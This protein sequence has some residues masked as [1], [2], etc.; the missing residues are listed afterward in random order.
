MNGPVQII[1]VRGPVQASAVNGPLTARGL[2]ADAK[3]KT[4]NGSVVAVFERVEGVKSISLETVNGKLELTLPADANAEV[5]AESVNG[6]IQADKLTVKKNWPVGSE[7]RGTL[8]QGGTRAKASTVN[9]SIRIKLAE[10]SQRVQ[11][12]QAEEPEKG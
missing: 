4:V 7:L 8:G 3:F 11:P 1:G 2:A 6:H 10:P 5:S 9:G 12:V